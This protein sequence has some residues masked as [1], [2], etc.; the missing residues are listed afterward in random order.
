M[1]ARRHP[2]PPQVT[3]PSRRNRREP[4]LPHERDESS[5]PGAPVQDET[6]KLGR[7]AA[8]D[9]ERGLV[10]TDRGPVLERLNAEHFTPAARR[11]PRKRR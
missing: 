2:A 9:I 6:R 8:S 11:A 3:T 10:D 7:Q 5:D 4:R 1:T